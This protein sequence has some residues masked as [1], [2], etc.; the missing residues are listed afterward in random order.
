MSSEAALSSAPSGLVTRPLIT[1]RRS[2]WPNDDTTMRSIRKQLEYVGHVAEG[3]ERAYTD[4][5]IP[6]REID[7]ESARVVVMSDLHRGSRDGADDFERCEPAYAA[8]VEHYFAN[9]YELLAL[10]D[11]DELWENQAGPVIHAYGRLMEAE[12]RFARTGRYYRFWG[13]HDDLWQFPDAVGRDLEKI[14]GPL[15]VPEALKLVVRTAGERIGEIF[16]LHGHQG[17]TFSDRYRW[18]SKLVVRLIWRNIQR[19]TR[20][21]STTAATDH[22]LRG[23]HDI[24]MYNWANTKTGLILIAGHTHRPVFESRTQFGKLQE[25]LQALWL[26]GEPTREDQDRMEAL[27]IELEHVRASQF[28]GGDRSAEME[29][30]CY[31]NAGCCSFGDGDITC[32]EI[33]DGRIK[34]VRWP[35]D[36]GE[37][38]PKEL[39]RADVRDLFIRLAAST[40]APVVPAPR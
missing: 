13:N 10:G 35:R 11:V 4:S 31:F 25:E 34:L 12:S 2:A 1:A 20:R 22:R 17:T 33:I 23:E 18:L 8:A 9:G 14:Y 7:L 15:P 16:L 6:T 5:E 30:P 32:I 39:D 27:T 24:A 26:L 36:D 3:L 38:A 21:P 37:L 28:Q 29:R 19:I 40:A